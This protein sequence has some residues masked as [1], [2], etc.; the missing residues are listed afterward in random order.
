M[1]ESLIKELIPV[2]GKRY[3]FLDNRTKLL[4][5]ENII[6]NISINDDSDLV[7]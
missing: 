4:E 3:R 5:A 6:I 1:P 2:I 7:R